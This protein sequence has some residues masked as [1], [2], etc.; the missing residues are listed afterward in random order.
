MCKRTGIKDEYQNW[1][2]ACVPGGPGG[3]PPASCDQHRRHGRACEV[4]AVGAGLKLVYIL[5]DY[6]LMADKFAF[7][8][9]SV[10]PLYITQALDLH[11]QHGPRNGMHASSQFWYTCLIPVL[12]RV[13]CLGGGYSLFTHIFHIQVFTDLNIHVQQL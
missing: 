4:R 8:L 2:E 6:R 13:L 12:P 1:D 11:L 10:L 9:L 7:I 3:V 5:K